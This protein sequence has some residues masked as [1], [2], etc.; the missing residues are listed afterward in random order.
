MSPQT[1]HVPVG[2][3]LAIKSNLRVGATSD[4]KQVPK[5]LE[6]FVNRTLYSTYRVYSLFETWLTHSNKMAGPRCPKRFWMRIAL[7]LREG[8]VWEQNKLFSVP[9][10]TSRSDASLFDRVPRYSVIRE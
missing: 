8:E 4:R 7:P 5:T 9:D 3:Q 1:V 2:W 6:E 10:A